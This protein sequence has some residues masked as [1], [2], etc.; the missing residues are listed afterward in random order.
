MALFFT[1]QISLILTADRE[2]PHGLRSIGT[3]TTVFTLA[4][5]GIDYLISRKKS[6]LN[7]DFEKK[8]RKALIGAIVIFMIA[9][10]WLQY[11]VYWGRDPRTYIAYHDDMV[12]V[13]KYINE[14]KSGNKIILV[15][16]SYREFT[17]KYLTHNKS[18]YQ[19]LSINKISTFNE[20]HRIK[21]IF[22]FED[23][24]TEIINALYAKYGSGRLSSYQ[25]SLDNHYL[26]Y[27]FQP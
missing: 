25:S 19:F 10:G 14:D 12:A 6:I 17:A 23:H 3:T 16:N 21:F 22:V 15:S 13:A 2:L 4:G 11:F 26:F 18:D 8:Y 9:S 24:S 7:I 5:I 1:L 27:V 20:S